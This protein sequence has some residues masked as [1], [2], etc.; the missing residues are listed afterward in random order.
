MYC[1]SASHCPFLP[2]SSF[3]SE[4]LRWDLYSA[5]NAQCFQGTSSSFMAVLKPKCSRSDR[6]CRV[7]ELLQLFRKVSFPLVCPL[8][9]PALPWAVPGQSHKI[10]AVSHTPVSLG[11]PHAPFHGLI[12][13]K[14]VLFCWPVCS[15]ENPYSALINFLWKI[16]AGMKLREH[17]QKEQ[18]KGS[19]SHSLGHNWSFCVSTQPTGCNYTPRA[20]PCLSL[21]GKT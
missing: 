3:S 5:N 10:R 15:W 16:G 12:S 7:V 9:C 11:G 4:F 6:F 19:I 2:R 18:G 8:A 13:I 14:E 17:L 20:H 21:P 1:S